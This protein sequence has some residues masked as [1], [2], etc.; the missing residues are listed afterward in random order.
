MKA[1]KRDEAQAIRPI[2]LTDHSFVSR[3][4]SKYSWSIYGAAPRST[5]QFHKE[6]R[7]AGAEAVSISPRIEI[8]QFIQPLHVQLIYRSGELAALAQAKTQAL[9]SLAKHAMPRLEQAVKEQASI[10]QE[11]R[12]IELPSAELGGTRHISRSSEAKGRRL[13]AAPQRHELVPF[14]SAYPLLHRIE[15]E[16]VAAVK[17]K[18]AQQLLDKV[19]Q[20]ELKLEQELAVIRSKQ[21]HTHSEHS[22]LQQ[23]VATAS[24]AQAIA[25][26]A[27]K[28]PS[29]A[30]ELPAV[31]EQ[32]VAKEPPAV[33]EQSV[34]KEPPTVIEQS[35]VKEP[36]TAIEPPA[37]IKLPAAVEPPAA[38]K[39]PAAVEPLAKAKPY[40]AAVPGSTAE[41]SVVR[42]TGAISVKWSKLVQQSLLS[43]EAAN[44]A[45]LHHLKTADHGQAAADSSTANVAQSTVRLRKRA[46]LQA[47]AKLQ[48]QVQNKQIMKHQLLLVSESSKQLIRKHS[49]ALL[50]NMQ[51]L[52]I[53][54]KP[55][56]PLQLSYRMTQDQKSLHERKVTQVHRTQPLYT[57][58]A[59]QRA[60]SAIQRSKQEQAAGS[61]QHRNEQERAAGNKQRHN[62]QEQAAG[63]NQ[64][65][66]E[67]VIMPKRLQTS[68]QQI[69]GLRDWNIRLNQQGETVVSIRSGQ[70]KQQG[71]ATTTIRLV[72]RKLS[73]HE[74]QLTVQ[75]MAKQQA[76]LPVYRKQKIER[77][78]RTGVVL[79][80][81]AA[82][83]NKIANTKHH[84]ERS[85]GNITK[86]QRDDR[87]SFYLLT[88]RALVARIQQQFYAAKRS[89]AVL[90]FA[91]QPAKLRLRLPHVNRQIT[92]LEPV[93]A[94]L[95]QLLQPIVRRLQSSVFHSV[96]AVEAQSSTAQP[97]RE[98]YSGQ[99]NE[100][101]QLKLLTLVQ[102][103][104]QQ[105]L[106][107][108]RLYSASSLTAS[109]PDLERKRFKQ[110]QASMVAALN[111]QLDIRP[112]QQRDKARLY[113]KPGQTLQAGS[114]P[115]VRQARSEFLSRLLAGRQGQLER[116]PAANRAMLEH[117][118]K[119]EAASA[120]YASKQLEQE[121]MRVQSAHAVEQAADAV[122]Q[123]LEDAGNSIGQHYYRRLVQSVTAPKISSNKQASLQTI[124]GLRIMAALYNPQLVRGQI[125]WEQLFGQP[126]H[127]QLRASTFAGQL[128][129]L[130][131]P[132]QRNASVSTMQMNIVYNVE[133]NRV[134][135]NDRSGST[136]N[137]WRTVEAI[138]RKSR[139]APAPAL[140]TMAKL[141]AIQSQML[142]VL[143]DRLLQAMRQGRAIQGTATDQAMYGP[144]IRNQATQ[145]VA[146][147]SSA[148]YDLASRGLAAEGLALRSQ[149]LQSIAL[150]SPESRGLASRGLAA[151]GL[152]LRSQALQSI[153]LH[154]P[155]S[156]GLAVE[157]L[158]LRI[159]AT[160][161]LA[162][163]SPVLRGL[164]APDLA[165]QVLAQH[166]PASR[167][168][169]VQVQAPATQAAH[170]LDQPAAARSGQAPLQARQQFAFKVSEQRHPLAR[171]DVKKEAAKQAEPHGVKQLQQ[172]VQRLE[173]QLQEQQ[174]ELVKKETQSS[175]RQLVDQLYEELSRKLRME[176]K[177][178]GR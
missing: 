155:A 89:Q 164:A 100:Q 20:V 174:A 58:V 168:P 57:A 4:M 65:H 53:K 24:K 140:A 99:R 152:A 124:A 128:P 68:P 63:N 139:L 10:K 94:R 78:R 36:P 178:I 82:S 18:S 106:L 48:E 93:Q 21:Q 77:A 47:K 73:E 79:P 5:M 142:T 112:M 105:T 67:Q 166:N 26:S 120:Q 55:N 14:S 9:A 39:L 22:G 108:R 62:E 64:Q 135:R 165:V 173:Q 29:A 32:S 127:N 52:V 122:M 8:K 151:E 51:Q 154:S 149:A 123:K 16:R 170:A 7:Q 125:A 31:I 126:Q 59:E 37:A 35:V 137:R 91:Q 147:P 134:L 96:N 169:A 153:A 41:L 88:K 30:K 150:H 95:E 104:E 159:Q 161:G 66:S 121:L 160:Q 148:T 38:I 46:I 2:H 49:A 138:P 3:L 113:Y 129:Q 27:A 107:A 171:L 156:R 110:T 85:A 119:R 162:P 163:H 11:M 72:H 145:I 116:R 133:R 13:L 71:S 33:I 44:A 81:A 23:H 83:T 42:Q 60:S 98:L 6:Q 172:T 101:K 90:I 56:E 92:V 19:G 76:E 118:Q 74:Q 176:A 69:A 45:A 158:A 43:V 28:E 86:L 17:R 1:G 15:Q 97:D 54:S 61:K 131:L 130:L 12:L 84:N 75:R 50:R 114:M 175:T 143:P 157:G 167:G 25:S 177:R 34:A 103:I 117:V 115:A 109:Q 111:N 146:A 40:S 87:L 141:N 144:A 80:A 102:R 132:A 136:A 70:E